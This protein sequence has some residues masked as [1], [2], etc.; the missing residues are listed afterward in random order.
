MDNTLNAPETLVE[1]V[2]Y[3]SDPDVCLS[4]LAGL[5]WPDGNVACP[6]CGSQGVTFLRN[7]RRWKCYERHPRPQFS[8]KAGT[9]FEAPPIALEKWL[10]AVWMHWNDKN[11]ITSTDGAL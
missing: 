7:Q 6:T 5:R 1:A 4:F 10:P 2:R 3:F 8:I 9:I 11:G